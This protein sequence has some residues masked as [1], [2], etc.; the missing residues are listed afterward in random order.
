MTS[1]TDLQVMSPKRT[2]AGSDADMTDASLSL[3]QN[4]QLQGQATMVQARGNLGP[5]TMPTPAGPSQVLG[6]QLGATV[7]A[8]N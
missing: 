7:V 3:A 4:Q 1:S 6:Q 5:F 8:A 2:R